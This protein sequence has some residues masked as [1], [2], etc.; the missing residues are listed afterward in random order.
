MSMGDESKKTKLD[1]EE[2]LAAEEATLQDISGVL[3][4]MDTMENYESYSVI[5]DGKELFSFRVRGLDDEEMDRC[6]SEATKYVRNKKMGGITM[7]TNF[8]TAK[9]NSLLFVQATQSG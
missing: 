7:P 3:E 9:Y 8:N 5:R 6:R 1:N 4:A 2:L